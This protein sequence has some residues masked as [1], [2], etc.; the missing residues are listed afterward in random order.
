[1]NKY[2]LPNVGTTM[3]I[4]GCAYNEGLSGSEA[5]QR[6]R[7]EKSRRREYILP[8][9]CVHVHVHVYVCRT[10]VILQSRKLAYMY[11]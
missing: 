8:N 7:L 2:N 11:M 5:E 3:Y 9:P 10:C 1:M 4:Y 6:V